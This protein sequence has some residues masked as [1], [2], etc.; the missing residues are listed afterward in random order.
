[1]EKII[2]IFCIVEG[3]SAAVVVIQNIIRT[4]ANLKNKKIN[5][6]REEELHNARL[7]AL[8]AEK[9]YYDSKKNHDELWFLKQ[10]KGEEE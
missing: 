8:L 5:K 7:E 1:M 2:F 10:M 4:I 9:N 3:F 6:K